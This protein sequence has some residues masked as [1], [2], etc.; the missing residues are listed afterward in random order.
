MRVAGLCLVAACGQAA[1]A[2]AISQPQVRSATTTHHAPPHE[3]IDVLAALADTSRDVAW[4]VPGAAQL[5]LG[6][7]P[8]QA[9]EGAEALEVTPLDERGNDVRIGVRLEH[10][11]F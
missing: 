11:R 4:I 5:E 3:P 2:P 8:I 1:V 10:V 9:P 7:A 6:G